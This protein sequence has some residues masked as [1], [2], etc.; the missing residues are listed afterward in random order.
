M[1]FWWG[2]A[3]G[4]KKGLYLKSW[5]AI[6]SPIISGGLG[7]QDLHNINQA[8]IARIGWRILRYHDSLLSKILK[9][10]YFQNSSPFQVSIKSNSSWVWK[11]I[12]KNIHSFKKHCIWEV[13]NGLS[14]HIWNDNWILNSIPTVNTSA[15]LLSE[16]Y[17]MVSDLIDSSH[18]IWNRQTLASLFVTQT[19]DDILNIRLPMHG[20]DNI[21]WA[22]NRTEEFYVKSL[23]QENYRSTHVDSVIDETWCKIWN[24]NVIP[25][26]KVFIWKCYSDILPLNSR[27]S[28]IIIIP[29]K[30]CALCLN[31]EETFR[32]LFIDCPF[33]K[34]VWFCTA[35]SFIPT[36]DN[37]LTTKD[38]ISS[39]FS[40]NLSVSN[41]HF[42]YV[43]A[44]ILRF[45]WKA[46]CTTIFENKPQNPAI[47]GR[48]AMIFIHSQQKILEKALSSS[49]TTTA[50]I[51]GWVPPMMNNFKI[52]VDA[53]FVSTDHCIDIGFLLRHNTGSFRGAKC[54]QHRSYSSEE[55]EGLALFEAL[56]WSR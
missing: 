16:D 18:N 15:A 30:D 45:I 22:L 35:L 55:A 43:V 23:S 44:T 26:I 24:L 40:N 19:Q 37:H 7:F 39:W 51:Q 29:S 48:E 41:Y 33:A 14:I 47:I 20:N 6:C 2:K 56:K 8:Q 9:A 1:D 11:G 27:L 46:R 50:P 12:L 36:V 17:K 42:P 4:K 32:H 49:G 54:L 21:K 52:N 34:A 25:K 10:K 31:Q 13:G 5:D 28:R 38:W 53:S 3:D